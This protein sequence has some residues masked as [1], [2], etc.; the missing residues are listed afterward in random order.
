MPALSFRLFDAASD[1]EAARY[2]ILAGLAET[3]AAFRANHIAPWLGDLVTL[4][5][6]LAALV[7][8]A[9]S[10]ETQAGPV[11][12]VDW[13]AG[14]LVRGGPE[15]PLAVGLARWALPQIEGAIREGRT[16][17]DFVAERAALRAV[18]VVPS[19]RDE[20]FLLVRDASAVCVLRYRVSPLAAPDG[21]HRALRTERLDTTLDPMAPPTAWKAALAEAA[22]DLPA[23]AAF[24]LDAEVDVPVDATLVPI[25]KRKLLGLIGTWGEA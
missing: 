20:G 11:V 22:P 2:R 17:Y 25:A 14:R 23:P 4:H 13:A 19:Y 21:P 6:G 9:E 1:A 16:L 8:G 18:G 5:R 15:A 3:R 7:A 12:D 10:V 24:R